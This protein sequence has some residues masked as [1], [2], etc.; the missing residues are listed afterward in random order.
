MK[1]K[2]YTIVF[3]SITNLLFSEVKIIKIIDTNKFRLTTNDTIVLADIDCP[4]LQDTSYKN[5][6]IADEIVKYIEDNIQGRT[7]IID[8]PNNKNNE[9]YV[10]TKY[11]F[12]KTNVN[13][14]Y[15]KKG[16]AKFIENVDSPYYKELH[17]ASVNAQKKGK[18]IW[19]DKLESKLIQ[20][21][22]N[23]IHPR[24][25]SRKYIYGSYYKIHRDNYSN[26]EDSPSYTIGIRPQFSTPG[27]GFEFQYN[28]GKNSFSNESYREFLIS[29]FYSY[30]LKYYA[31]ETQV[32]YF[33][34]NY[35]RDS[36]PMPLGIIHSH[37]FGFIK[38]VYVSGDFY[39]N[40]FFRAG[41]GFQ[42]Y[43]PYLHFYIGL[44]RYEK[45]KPIYCF[46]IEPLNKILIKLVYGSTSYKNEYALRILLG[47]KI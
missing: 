16:Y 24:V 11:P 44:E 30:I 6:Y 2:L 45:L 8:F 22:Q 13:L 28:Y 34:T 10:F 29:G 38:Y 17:D 32:Y 1:I 3:L 35:P 40:I 21:R 20:M 12:S 25:V 42:L 43:K 26:I 15:I 18:W 27:L 7:L 47:Y 36:A 37:K 41:F 23:K 39:F 31:L 33:K 9:A 5:K 14:E 4:S 19:N 46:D